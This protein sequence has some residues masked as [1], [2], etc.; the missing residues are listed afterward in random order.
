MIQSE[1][2]A[3]A[4][5]VKVSTVCTHGQIEMARLEMFE[6]KQNLLD[7]FDEIKATSNPS[8]HN[9]LQTCERKFTSVENHVEGLASGLQHQL[10]QLSDPSLSC[11][12]QN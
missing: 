6:F 10:N 4:N 3:T 7:L 1:Q 9:K 12:I 11:P 5:G 8:L 2:A